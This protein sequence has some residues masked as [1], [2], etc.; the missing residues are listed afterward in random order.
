M[1]FEIKSSNS[2]TI[3]MPRQLPGHW[4][5][6]LYLKHN[7]NAQA[8]ASIQGTAEGIQKD[9]QSL[10]N[11]MQKSIDEANAFINDFRSIYLGLDEP[12]TLEMIMDIPDMS[13]GEGEGEDLGSDEQEFILDDGSEEEEEEIKPPPTISIEKQ[14][15][16][17]LTRSRLSGRKRKIE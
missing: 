7:L 12:I 14:Q 6:V 9:I 5:Q 8:I 16:V 13:E 10:I 2:S 17:P 15:H 3:S 4:D 1:L 11:E